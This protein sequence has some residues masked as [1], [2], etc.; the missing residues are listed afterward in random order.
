M[1]YKIK[2]EDKAALINR[3]DK[4]DIAVD[5]SKIKDNKLEGYFELTVNNPEAEAIIKTILK[6]SP[7]IT[8]VKKI[9]KS[10]LKEIIREELDK[11]KLK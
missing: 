8:K 6:Q 9:T 1:V 2:L 4:Q 11:I 5:T 10:Q 3:L 7:K